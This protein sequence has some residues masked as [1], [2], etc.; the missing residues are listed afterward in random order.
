MDKQVVKVMCFALAEYARIEGMRAANQARLSRGETIA[1][2][3]EYFNQSAAV[4]EQL[5]I[6]VV[7]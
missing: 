4:L 5:A 2:P 3:E 6:D 7:N 1:Y